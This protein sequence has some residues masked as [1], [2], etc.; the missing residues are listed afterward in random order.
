MGVW[1]GGIC[2]FGV[3]VIEVGWVDSLGVGIKRFIFLTAEEIGGSHVD[4]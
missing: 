3:C 4:D 1:S 2:V